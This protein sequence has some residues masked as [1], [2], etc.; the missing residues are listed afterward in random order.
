LDVILGT[1]L[2]VTVIEATRRTVGLILPLLAGVFL[3]YGFF[4][5]YF[6]GPFGHRGYP[7][8]RI[9]A[10]QVLTTIGLFGSPLGASSTFVAIFMIFSAFLQA[11]GTGQSFIDLAV[12]FFG[13]IRGGPAKVAVFASSLFGAISGSAVANVAGTGTFTIPL[14][15]RTGYRPHF[16]GAVEAAAST[17]G[18]LMP[19]VMPALLYYFGVFVSVDLE[20]V[21]TKLLGLP[22]SELPS[23]VAVMRKAYMF[24]PI[25]LLVYLMVIVLYTPTRAAVWAIAATVAVSVFIKESRM[26][27][28]ELRLALI[29]GA[30]SLIP[31]INACACAGI[32]VGI[33]MLT[34]LGLRLSSILITLSGGNLAVLLVLTMG[35]SILLGMG[36]PTSAAYIILA[37]LIAPS[38]VKL[39][40]S[41]MAAHMFV[42][43]FGVLAPVTPPVALAA[44]TAAGIASS[45]PMRTGFVAWK[46]CLSGFILPF[47]FVYNPELLMEGSF[48]KLA[49]AIPTAVLG[50]GALS[51]A[52]IGYL[53]KEIPPLNRL[54]FIV[55][56][57]LLIKPGLFTDITGLVL[58][59]AVVAYQALGIR[60]KPKA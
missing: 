40:L 12:S 43:Y 59:V 13:G 14:M 1:I 9:V 16:A 21:R 57:L 28:K 8:S 49:L 24:L 34:G 41:V 46:L 6:P 18:Q 53:Y 37:V 60:M 38:L 39:G 31:V 33:L 47:I 55:A 15:K 36:V 3:V 10:D 44:Y 19:P 51:A 26:G 4:G 32:I 54:I 20:A 27:M 2:I 23:R 58:L 48:W 42:F 25:F 52:G 7:V 5:P 30:E 35:A 29:K 50:I 17:G 45:D 56:A 22:R 11:S